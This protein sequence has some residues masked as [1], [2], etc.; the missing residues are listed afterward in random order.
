MGIKSSMEVR[1]DLPAKS[2][3][4][5]GLGMEGGD[6]SGCRDSPMVTV[7]KGIKQRVFYAWMKKRKRPLQ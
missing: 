3:P 7:T 1:L 6:Y 2:A 4:P 5:S